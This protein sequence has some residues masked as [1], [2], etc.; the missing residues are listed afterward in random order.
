MKISVSCLEDQA[1]EYQGE[2]VHL[3]H[4]PTWP[5]FWVPCP[6]GGDWSQRV[7]CPVQTP[8]VDVRLANACLF[9]VYQSRQDAEAFV[10]W[11]PEAV[12]AA[13]RGHR[14]MSG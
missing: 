10:T 4:S 11:I 14:N 9:V 5:H 6:V 7:S 2:G 12:A 13:E 1:L 8:P 3:I